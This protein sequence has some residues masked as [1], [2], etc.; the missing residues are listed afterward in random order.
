MRQ[1]WR[2]LVQGLHPTAY[3]GEYDEGLYLSEGGT[4]PE[5]SPV[6]HISE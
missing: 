1:R 6:D 3:T 4:A 5:Q 2:V